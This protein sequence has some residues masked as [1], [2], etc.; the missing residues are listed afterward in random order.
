MWRH[1]RYRV[2]NFRKTA[3]AAQTLIRCV[4]NIFWIFKLDIKVNIMDQVLYVQIF[5]PN[6]KYW[7]RA[8][9]NLN[10]FFSIL[11]RFKRLFLRTDFSLFYKTCINHVHYYMF[12]LENNR[13]KILYFYV[14]ILGPLKRGQ[15]HLSCLKFWNE[16]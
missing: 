3:V 1:F 14:F 11:D 9:K 8:T 16:H 4:F 12:H 2:G 13:K 5:Y 6:R 7:I 15:N 10:N